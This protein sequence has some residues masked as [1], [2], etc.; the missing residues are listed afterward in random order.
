MSSRAVIPPVI[1]CHIF[2]YRR[3]VLRKKAARVGSKSTIR[4]AEKNNFRHYLINLHIFFGLLWAGECP[5]IMIDNE[6]W[7]HSQQPDWAPSLRINLSQGPDPRDCLLIGASAYPMHGKTDF[8]FGV[9]FLGSTVKGTCFI[10]C[11]TL[12]RGKAMYFASSDSW[13]SNGTVWFDD[14]TVVDFNER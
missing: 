5:K 2:P 8:S 1:K 6:G 14:K 12:W 10:C 4:S 13:K 9:F 7:Y 3:R 11:A